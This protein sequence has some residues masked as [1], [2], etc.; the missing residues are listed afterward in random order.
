MEFVVLM[1]Q[2]ISLLLPILISGIFFIFS[3]KNRWFESLNRPI[4]G[5]FIFMGARIFGANK[6]WRA[7]IFYVFVGTLITFVLHSLA[8]GQIWIARVYLL[9]SLI[10]GPAMTSSYAAAEL[11]NSFIKR[12]LGRPAGAAGG[13]LQAFF[14]NV[15]GALASG[16]VLFCFGVQIELLAVSF[17][18]SFVVHSTTDVLMRSLHLKE[19][20]KK[21]NS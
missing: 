7:P 9:D 11:I 16:I 4:D 18:L 10:L 12:R 14:D 19:S 13:K 5:G 17:V 3:I 2:G 21:R 15:D 8:P 20:K 6:N 1:G